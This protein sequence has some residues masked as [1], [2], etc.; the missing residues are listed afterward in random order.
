MQASQKHDWLVI[1]RSRISSGFT[2][3]ELLITV[4]VV[5]VIAV[6]V[7]VQLNPIQRFKE[8]RDTNRQ[9]ALQS[10]SSAIELYKVD[11]NGQLPAGIDG[12]WRMLG[13]ATDSCDVVCGSEGGTGESTFADDTDGSFGLGIYS[14]V[15]YD[16]ANNWI[17]LSSTGLSSGVGTYTSSVKDALAKVEWEEFS[18]TPVRPYGKEL[19]ANGVSETAY[20]SGNISMSN[21]LLLYHLNDSSGPIQDFSGNGRTADVSGNGVTFGAAGKLGSSLQFD[22]SD[23]YIIDADA[24]AYLNGLSAITVSVW[25]KSD[26]TATDNA[27]L[28]GE[29]PVGDGTDNR[30]SMRYDVAGYEGGGTNLI[31]CGLNINGTEYNIESSSGLQ[32]TEWQHLVLTWEDGDD[33]LLFVNGQ[34]DALTSREDGVSGQLSSINGLWVGGGPKSDWNGRIDEL[35]IWGRR[36]SAT[37]IQ[38]L[39]LRGALRLRHQVRVCDDSACSGETFV[40]PDGTAASFYSEQSSGGSGLPSAILTN[41]PTDQ[42]FQYQTTFETDTS[43][44]SPELRDVFV[45]NALASAG[46]GVTLEDSCLDLSGELEPYLQSIPKD[47]LVGSDMQT[48]Y[49]VNQDENGIVSLR[50]CE[51]EDQNLIIQR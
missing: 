35:A 6:V 1:R 34:E 36:L 30:L 4:A 19:P 16:T 17:E 32:T 38:A 2:A 8:T 51:A 25:I 22:G 14:D 9:Q 31:K 26:V 28:N 7:F 24:G 3:I 5:G 23:D 48:F 18:W 49:A 12:R 37:E 39:Y 11:N 50:A 33:I 10:L 46:V 42:Y 29:N 15:Q 21:N 43:S 44:F 27:F 41:L 47:P 40:G 45:Q 20:V 13:T